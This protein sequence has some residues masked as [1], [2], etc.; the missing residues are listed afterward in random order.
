LKPRD[1]RGVKALFNGRANG[2]CSNFG[3]FNFT[4][5]TDCRL[6]SDDTA[7]GADSRTAAADTIAVDA[8]WFVRMRAHP[9]LEP[10]RKTV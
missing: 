6:W 5:R 8:P 10:S 7:D 1:L 9:H 2:F 4:A 3:D